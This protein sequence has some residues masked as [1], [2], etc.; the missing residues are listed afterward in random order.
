MKDKIPTEILNNFCKFITSNHWLQGVPGGFCSNSP[1]RLV[2]AFGNG[3]YD[4]SAGSFDL[5]YS[6]LTLLI[7]GSTS[8]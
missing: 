2:N 5:E 6:G 8:I 4:T 3:D 7:S 1:K